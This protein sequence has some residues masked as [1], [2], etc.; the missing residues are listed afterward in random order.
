[1]RGDITNLNFV[2]ETEIYFVIETENLKNVI[3]RRFL[4]VVQQGHGFFYS[5][6]VRHSSVFRFAVRLLGEE[7]NEST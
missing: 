7:I 3:E 2:M 5:R 6:R 1:M 4:K